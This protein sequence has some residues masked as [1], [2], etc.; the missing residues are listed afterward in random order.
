ME[1]TTGYEKLLRLLATARCRSLKVWRLPP[2]AVV[3]S[4]ALAAFA[5]AMAAFLYSA[6]AW[7]TAHVS[8]PALRAIEVL[9]GLVAAVLFLRAIGKELGQVLS[10]ILAVAAWPLVLLHLWLVDPIYLRVGAAPEG[11]SPTWGAIAARWLI[12]ALVVLAV[13]A[14]GSILAKIRR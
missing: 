5:A 6:V 7:R 2:F 3:G 4:V 1:R 11:R 14:I 12:A 9:A 8:I 13:I 10:G